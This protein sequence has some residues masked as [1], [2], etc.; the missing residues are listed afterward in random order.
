MYLLFR[1]FE[2]LSIQYSGVCIYTSFVIPGFRSIILICYSGVYSGVSKYY[3]YNNV[4]TSFVIPGFRSIIHTI[5]YIHHFIPGVS[6]YYPYNNVYTS[7]VIPGFHYNNVYT[8]FGGFEVL[9]IQ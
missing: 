8:S 1:G 2:V 9:S 3:P 6:K 4:Y 7:F 5:M